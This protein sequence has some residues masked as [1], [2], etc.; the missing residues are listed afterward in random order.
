MDTQFNG[1]GFNSQGLATFNPVNRFNDLLNQT[2]NLDD[3]Q[4]NPEV[5]LENILTK[6]LN[7][8]VPANTMDFSPQAVAD[9]IL[10]FVG[11][12]IAQQANGEKEAQDMLQQAREGIE[13]GLSEARDILSNLGKLS[14]E[15]ESK[16]D[17]TETLIFK[18]L[19]QLAQ[20]ILDKAES[21]ARISDQARLISESGQLSSKF[22]QSSEATIE[23]YTQDGDRVEVS[24]S[25]FIQSASN[26]SYVVNQQGSSYSYDFSAQS[27]ASFQFSVEGELDAEEQNAI[28]QVLNNVGD[29]AGQF[30]NGD[31]QAAFNSAMQLGFD[32]EELKSFSMDLRQ[33]T[34]VQVVESYQRTEQLVDPV[35]VSSDPG[36]AIDVLSQLQQLL[37]AAKE[38]ALIDKPEQT[39]KALLSDMIEMLNQETDFPV[40]DY[41][42]GVIEKL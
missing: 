33:S 34:S 37:E 24:Y 3:F 2:V 11:T 5:I 23:I 36:P 9:R 29:I 17:E 16:I 28:N 31:V 19:D 21:S 8:S 32:G 26:E 25:A 1:A 30:F 12:S 39:I 18:G 10:N 41:V 13:Q 35:H 6:T 20:S 15:V 40:S 4:H 7:A 38:N 14:A 42:K 22:K 27:S